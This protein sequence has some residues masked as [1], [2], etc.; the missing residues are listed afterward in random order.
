MNLLLLIL[1]MIHLVYIHESCKTSVYVFRHFVIHYVH[2]HLYLII[3]TTKLS[4]LNKNR[5]F[6]LVEV[7]LPT[8]MIIAW[9]GFS[10]AIVCLSLFFHKAS[11]ELMQFLRYS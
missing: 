7:S 5:V 9:I 4:N 3:T 6:A 2:Y 10:S 1:K 11:Q 8:Q